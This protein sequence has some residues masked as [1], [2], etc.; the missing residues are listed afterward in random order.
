MSKVDVTVAWEVFFQESNLLP[1]CSF[2]SFNIWLP[3]LPLKA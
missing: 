3:S 1:S 2:S